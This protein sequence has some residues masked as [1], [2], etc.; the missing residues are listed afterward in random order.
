M[1]LWEITPVLD[2]AAFRLHVPHC[3][4]AWTTSLRDHQKHAV[5]IW[6]SQHFSYISIKSRTIELSNATTAYSKKY[7]IPRVRHSGTLAATM[8]ILILNPNTT[9][10]MTDGVKDSIKLLGYEVRYAWCR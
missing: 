10:A 5:C 4:G 7:Q 6:Q 8:T 9:Q 1:E 3:I 2:T